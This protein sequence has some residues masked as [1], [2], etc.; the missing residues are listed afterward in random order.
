MLLLIVVFFACA[1]VDKLDPNLF[2]HRGKSPAGEK[3]AE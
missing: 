2:P 1:V 3:V